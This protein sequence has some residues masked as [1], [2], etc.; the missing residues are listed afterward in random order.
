VR[1]YSILNQINILIERRNIEKKIKKKIVSKNNIKKLST[2]FLSADTNFLISKTDNTEQ[3]NAKRN[4]INNTIQLLITEPIINS[5][6]KPYI[7]SP[8]KEKNIMKTIDNNI[9]R[10]IL[11]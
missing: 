1:E 5:V 3:A 11:E 2:S 4:E 6:R 10:T 7:L 8:V 9:P